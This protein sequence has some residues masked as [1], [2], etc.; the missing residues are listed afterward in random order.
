MSRCRLLPVVALL[1]A[2]C[3][4]DGPPLVAE[5]VVVTRPV[6]GSAMSAGYFRLRNPGQEAVVVTAI[7]SPD[8]ARVEIHETIIDDGI[9][10]MRS[11]PEIR[12][13]PGETV[14][15][16]RGGRHLMLS[17]PVQASG[18]VTLEFLAGDTL[19]LAVSVA[20]REG[21]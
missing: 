10:R 16:R 19:V 15:F 18:P 5:D 2:A 21:A 3:S 17:G 6:P 8:F 14:E 1:L 12:L 7:R 20:A 4:P 11:V 13:G 9:A